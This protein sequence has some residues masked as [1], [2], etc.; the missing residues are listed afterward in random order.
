MIV[1]SLTNHLLL[2]VGV[3]SLVIGIALIGTMEK[4]LFLIGG[5]NLLLGGGCIWGAHFK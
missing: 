2:I 3:L 1:P 4:E 5:I